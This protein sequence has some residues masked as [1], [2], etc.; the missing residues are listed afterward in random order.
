M[1]EEL[2]SHDSK[3]AYCK[4][5]KDSVAAFAPGR[6]EFLGN[7]LDYN[8]GTVLGAAINAGI[9]GLA[10]PT[11]DD[12]F[13][14]FSESFEKAVITGSINHLEKQT[15]EK[16]WGNYC[17]G[18][19][20]ALQARE[21]APNHG[22]SLILTTDLPM[23]AGLS[24][25]AAVELTT[26]LCLLQLAGKNISKNEWVTICREAENQ[27]VG[28][29]CGIL[30]QGTSAFGEIDRVVR[31]DCAHEN[32]STIAL[33]PDT[34]FWIF[35]TGIKHDLVDS[36]YGTRNQECMDA[37]FEMRKIDD[38]LE[39]LAHGSLETAM[40]VG[41]PEN[42]LKRVKHVIGE[43]ERVKQFELGLKNATPLQELGKLLYESH[44]SSSKLFENSVPEL[45]YLVELLNSDDEVWGARLTG[46]GFGG[47]VLAWSTHLF[48]QERANS[49][50]Q[51]YSDKFEV[52]PK[53]H[54]FNPSCGAH[55]K[56]PLDK[57]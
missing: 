30:D 40:N 33:P 47:A 16:S 32:Y 53:F 3:E 50:A 9:Y 34:A 7:H 2:S 19:L 45:D 27:W 31:I 23:A 57:G 4:Y 14:L 37:L 13:R 17:L 43:Q 15:G 41:L 56:D 10:K 11:G 18:V 29:P 8:G 5:M 38:S 54:S 55:P 42:L 28:L 1:N 52:E 26:A 46:G 12:S 39:H 25:S 49:I 22:F 35:D 48:S 44:L 51:K 20:N 24:S 36:L 21:L 6:I